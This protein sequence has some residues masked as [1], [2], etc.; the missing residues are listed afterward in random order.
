VYCVAF[1]SKEF[2]CLFSVSF[3]LHFIVVHAIEDFIT[4]QHSSSLLHDQVPY[5]GVSVSQHSLFVCLFVCRGKD[6][7]HSEQP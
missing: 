5:Y 7:Q 1:F 2:F 4:D 6:Y 3:F